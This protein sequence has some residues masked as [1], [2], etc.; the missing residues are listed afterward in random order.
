MAPYQFIM[1]TINRLL[2]QGLSGLITLYRLFISPLLGPRCRFYPSCSEYAQES[3][4]QYGVIKGLWF[5]MCR[6]LRC[7]PG[8]QGG[9]DPVPTGYKSRLQ[10]SSLR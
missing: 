6:L 1:D 2:I 7:H 4:K 8:C 10:N 3:L 9:F 5:S